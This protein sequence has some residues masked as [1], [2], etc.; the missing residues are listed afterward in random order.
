MTLYLAKDN[1]ELISHCKCTTTAL[2]S[3]PGQMDCP[4]CGCGWLFTCITCRKAFTFA[5]AINIDTP[6]AELAHRDLAAF[7]GEE[8]D[9]KD[10]GLWVKDMEMLMEGVELGKRYVYLDG[11]FLPANTDEKI[12]VEG[13]YATHKLP[14]IPQA[15]AM[16]D[17]SVVDTILKNA[18]YWRERAPQPKHLN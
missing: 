17:P 12:D 16:T 2:V 9:P 10:V 4:W 1:D 11:F 15:R 6:L 7:L 8:P 14:W 3:V 13:I 5:K 18:S